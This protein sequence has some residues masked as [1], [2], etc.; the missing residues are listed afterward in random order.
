[1]KKLV[2]VLVLAV[3]I[4]VSAFADHPDGWGVGI[5]GTFGGGWSGG[6]IGYGA[7]LSLKAPQLP[8]FWGVNLHI[9]SDYFGFGIIG[10]NYIIHSPLVQD[11][12]LH[13][14]LGIGGWLNFYNYS[15]SAPTDY[16][17]TSFAF[18]ARLPIGLSFQPISLLEVFLDIAPSLGI[19]I[20]SEGKYGNTV[21]HEGGLHFPAGGWPFA[22]GIRLWF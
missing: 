19:A 7:A 18:G 15:Y 11:V 2:L 10:D 6:G 4:S 16:S 17:Y 5:M 3:I 9:G 22:I 20:D 1:M 14:Y 13:W 8:I 12:G 21:A